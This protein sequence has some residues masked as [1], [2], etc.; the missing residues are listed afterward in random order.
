[1]ILDLRP[2]QYDGEY[3]ATR[4]E[5]MLELH[6]IVW[7]DHGLWRRLSAWSEEVPESLIPH[8]QITFAP[9]PSGPRA[10]FAAGDVPPA[11]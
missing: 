2:T 1:L 9:K 5:G 4:R 11:V 8:S 10:P 6:C 3:V 7:R